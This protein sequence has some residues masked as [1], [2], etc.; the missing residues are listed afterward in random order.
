MYKGTYTYIY[1]HIYVYKE[2]LEKFIIMVQAY[3]KLLQ[4]VKNGDIAPC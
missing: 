2:K 3:N 4:P 1:T